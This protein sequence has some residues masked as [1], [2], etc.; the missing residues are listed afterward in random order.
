MPRAK[1]KV[2]NHGG[3]REGAGRKAA[4]TLLEKIA[5]GTA[6]RRDYQREGFEN[7]ADYRA[8]KNGNRRSLLPQPATLHPEASD[9]F[10]FGAEYVKT[11]RLM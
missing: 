9:E 6:Q 11:G 4:M 7:A 5:A 1:K 2:S 10:L 3:K 8:R